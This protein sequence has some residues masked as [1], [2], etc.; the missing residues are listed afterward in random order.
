MPQDEL[1]ELRDKQ[2]AKLVRMLGAIAGRL[3]ASLLRPKT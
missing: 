1:A 3:G 2:L